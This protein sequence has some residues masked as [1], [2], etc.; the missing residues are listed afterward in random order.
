MRVLFSFFVII[1]LDGG[2][3][4]CNLM[5]GDDVITGNGHLSP[6]RLSLSQN[7]SLS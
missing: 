5:S 3:G 2:K 7:P 6:V 1:S 4:R